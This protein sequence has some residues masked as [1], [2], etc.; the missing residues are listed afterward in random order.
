MTEERPIVTPWQV[1]GRV[2]YEKLIEQ[3]GTEP[4]T[5][6]LLGRIERAAGELHLQLR[7]GVFFSHRDLGWILDVHERGVKFGLYTGRG[8]SGPTTIG[9]MVPW[10]F[11]KY[12]QDK[13]D[14]KLYFQLTD[15]EKSLW[16]PPGMS[17]EETRFWTRENALDIVA[18][19]FKRGKTLLVADTLCARTLYGMAVEVAKH[20]TYSTV[21]AIFGFEDSANIGIIFFPAMQAVPAFLESRLVGKNVPCLIPAA[22]DQDP[23]WR[24][25]R[26][27]APK[28][29]FF[30]PAQIHSKFLPGLLAGGKMSASIPESAIFTTDGEVAAKRKIVNAF[31]GG[32]ATVE[33]QRRLGGDPEICPIFQYE[34]FLF[35]PDDAKLEDTKR[36]CLGGELL[37]GEHKEAL[38]GKVAAFL[39]SHQER[40]EEAKEVLD[41]FLVKDEYFSK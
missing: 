40:R 13:F 28:L 41:E 30:K 2:D 17:L 26:D 18:T 27:I 11:T 5:G 34:L 33:E 4:I 12:L 32:R 10:I 7:R 21:K 9:H 14:A 37:C 22:I 8:P 25:A 6:E 19:G 1:T 29:G 38:A 31:T 3:F 39:R 36:R 24:M 15:D 16:P 20:V 35:E 23:Y